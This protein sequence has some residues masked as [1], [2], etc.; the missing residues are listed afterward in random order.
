MT[1]PAA[2]SGEAPPDV[3]GQAPGPVGPPP[4]PY[5]PPGAELV[6]VARRRHAG[7]EP[8]DPPALT[9]AA[10]WT[11]LRASVSWRDLVAAVMLALVV[12]VTGVGTGALWSWI[13]PHVPVL[14]TE[15]GPILAEYYGESAFGQQATFGG[16]GFVGGLLLG[17]IAYLIR[18]R[19]GPILLLGLAAGCLA[20][21]WVSWKVGVRLG[22]EEYESLLQHAAPG[23]KFAMP[24][25]LDATGLLFLQPLVAVLAYV[26]VAAWSRYPDLK[27]D[28]TLSRGYG[29]HWGARRPDQ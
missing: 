23:R 10:L 28:P 15:N 7:D 27:A 22:Q 20:A 29:R 13:G 16:L 11:G 4:G 14:M 25:E 5:Q 9:P 18:R 2:G 26:L 8:D 6:P 3:L 1:P 19:R 24:V 21:A 17:P 12:A